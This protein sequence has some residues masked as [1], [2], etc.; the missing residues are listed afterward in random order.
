MMKTVDAKVTDKK[1]KEM[2]SVA[3]FTGAK[4][5]GA[6]NTIGAKFGQGAK[7]VSLKKDL[8]VTEGKLNK[9]LAREIGAYVIEQVV[10]GRDTIVVPQEFIERIEDL[11]EQIDV[12]KEEISN[13]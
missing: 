2:P 6:F 7:I 13:V 4:L 10:N 3:E 9:S 5:S 12:L 11:L 8:V 1:P